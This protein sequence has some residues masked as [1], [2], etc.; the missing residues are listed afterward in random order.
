MYKIGTFYRDVFEYFEENVKTE[1]EARQIRY[2]YMSR[3]ELVIDQDMD[4]LIT[5]TLSDEEL[6]FFP[7][8]SAVFVPY[9]GLDGLNI[10]ALK[11]RNIQ[12][13]NT[14]AHG[15]FVAER[16]LALTLAV[17]GKIVAS[18]NGMVKGSWHNRTVMELLYW[19]SLKGKKVAIFGY[20]TIGQHFHD[21]VKPFQVEVGIVKY[22]NRTYKDTLTFKD[23]HT[24]ADWCDVL[25]ITAPLTDNTKSA[26]DSDI[27]QV[28]TG[29]VL[30]NIGRGPIIDEEALYTA[31]ESGELKGF[32]SD[33]WFNY[34]TKETP[35]CE[36]SNYDLSQFDQVVM[37]P[38]NGGFEENS[39][40]VRYDDV[41]E[42]IYS[43][44]NK[45]GLD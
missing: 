18:H 19:S 28:L 31:L 15:F 1:F 2:V 32:G 7:K 29:S 23:L 21:M 8:L 42:T 43:I 5:G 36:P 3:K 14:S 11:Q 34:P 22:K 37:T 35:I 26:I 25:V 24:L 27:F 13:Y 6:K 39:R 38:H 41:I 10:P 4:M 17:M 30:I 20:G 33:V 16:A 9:T 40:K 44:I 12:V 45:N